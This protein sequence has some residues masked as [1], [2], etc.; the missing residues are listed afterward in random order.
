MTSFNDDRVLSEI[1]YLVIGRRIGK[2]NTVTALIR[3]EQ[4]MAH[5]REEYQQLALR[6]TPITL[7]E[8]KDMRMNSWERDFLIPYLDDE[9]LCWTVQHNLS[10]CSV[11]RANPC[12]T[13]EDALVNLLAPE[14]MKRLQEKT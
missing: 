6:G 12:S 4:A 14:L 5:V 13:Y 8:W 9:A 2:T 11:R 7:A 3:H 1:D 10:N